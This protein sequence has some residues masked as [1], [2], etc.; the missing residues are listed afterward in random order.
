MPVSSFEQFM[1]NDKTITDFTHNGNC[2]ECGNCCTNM[3]PI[4]ASE[5]PRIRA[6]IKKNHIRPHV[7]CLPLASPVL[8]ITCPFLKT[9]TKEKRCMIYDVRPFICRHFICSRSK[10]Q[11][12]KDIASDKHVLED[13]QVRDVRKLF[14][15]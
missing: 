15:P 6:Y 9:D 10:E 3:L 4:G 2:S 13:R 12:V 7:L 14:F 11:M 1:E 8:D 5:I